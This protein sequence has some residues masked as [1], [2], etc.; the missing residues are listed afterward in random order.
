M[1]VLGVPVFYPKVTDKPG[2]SISSI[3]GCLTS[4]WTRDHATQEDQPSGDCQVVV[5]R[6]MEPTRRSGLQKQ[7]CQNRS[8]LRGQAQSP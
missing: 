6:N 3:L 7:S 2:E 8:F 4:A 5:A 1:P